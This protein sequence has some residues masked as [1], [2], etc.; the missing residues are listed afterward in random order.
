M[1]LRQYL[2][3]YAKHIYKIIGG[4]MFPLRFFP[5]S[6]EL[7]GVPKGVDSCKN[8]DCIQVYPKETI[9][10]A[11]PKTIEKK[12]HPK[13]LCEYKRSSPEAFVLM[14]DNGYSSN[15]GANIS[16]SEK[17]IKEISRQIGH[18]IGE[19]T[20]FRSPAFLPKIQKYMCPVATLTGSEQS[21]Y[22]HWLFEILPRIHLLN[23]AKIKTEKIYIEN[24]TRFQKQSLSA[25]EYPEEQIINSCKYPFIFASKLI[26]PSPAGNSGNPPKWACQY[27]RDAFLPKASKKKF[28]KRIYISR[29]GARGRKIENEEEFLEFIG[30]YGFVTVKLEDIDFLQ[31]VGLFKSIDAVITPHGAGLSNLVFCRKNTKVIELFSPDAVNVCYWSLSNIVELNYYYM[32]EKGIKPPKYFA[33]HEGFDNIEVDIKK[34]EKLFDLA[35]VKKSK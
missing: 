31:Q 17:L 1:Y 35:G 25:L 21:C 27:L 11:K 26:V 14:I 3:P 8:F 29:A 23:K 9:K 13:F 10:R 16:K 18:N 34:L 28:P 6:F 22:F 15:D 24:K 20:I 5:R 7:F 30:K 19:H 4:I 12:I 33:A 2:K 32:I